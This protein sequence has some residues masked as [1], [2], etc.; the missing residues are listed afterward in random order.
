MDVT[1]QRTDSQ[2]SQT[3]GNG[4]RVSFNRDVHVKR[5]GSR[6]S[7][8]ESHHQETPPRVATPPVRREL[9]Q[10]LTE[11]GILAEAARVLS[12]AE[13]I[14]C[15]AQGGSDIV[16]GRVNTKNRGPIEPIRKFPE[17]QFNSLPLRGKKKIKTPV[18][19]SVSDASAKKSKKPSIFSLFG[20]RRDSEETLTAKKVARSKSDVGTVP[21]DRNTTVRKRNNSE[22]DEGVN[23]K[24]KAPPLSPIIE[25]TNKEDYFT[26][27]HENREPNARG[28]VKLED[29]D[30]IPSRVVSNNI[31]ETIT[32]LVTTQAK[33]TE[34]MHSSQLPAEK[35]PLTK[36][37]TVD[38]MVKRLSME[39]FSPPPQLA[40]PA[41]SYTRPKEQIIYAQ[42]VCDGDKT[43]QTVHYA[44]SHINGFH[45]EVNGR[46]NGRPSHSPSPFRDERSVLHL[47]GDRLIRKETPRSNSDEDEGLGFEIKKP[48]EENFFVDEGPITPNIRDVPPEKY[49][50]GD[51]TP[52]FQELSQRR[53]LLQSRINNRRFG[54]REILEDVSPERDIL[55]MRNSQ[56]RYRP[57]YENHEM[58]YQRSKSHDIDQVDNV[59]KYHKFGSQEVVNRYSPERSHLDMTQ[60]PSKSK[61]TS[62]YVEESRY[63]HDGKDGYRE[64]YRKETNIGT[65]GKPRTSESRSRERL[66]SPPRRVKEIDLGYIEDHRNFKV[67]HIEPNTSFFQDKYRGDQQPRSLESTT[68][69]D[70]TRSSP[71][72]GFR[73]NIR[74]HLTNG[75]RHES[76]DQYQ[77]SLKRQQKHQ[78]SFDKGDSGIENDYR[79]DSFN[80]DLQTR[81]KRR[82]IED[83]IKGCELFLRKERR[84]T[85]ENHPTRRH[86]NYIYRERSI[87]DGSHFDPRLDKYPDGTLRRS[88]E[89]SVEKTKTEK[90][91]SGLEKVKQLLTGSGKKKK[92]EKSA[93]EKYMVREDEMR[94]RYS[95]YRGPNATEGPKVRNSPKKCMWWCPRT[96]A[97]TLNYK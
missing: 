70:V 60:T 84:H 10:D 58:R 71:D 55:L 25:N 17:S 90:K 14:K 20:G 31:K 43:K 23:A 38:G 95:E 87:D 56:E 75:Y 45:S 67:G 88:R 92:D 16:G 11:E 3:N 53:E 65:D 47:N 42:V 36:G 24:K 76:M 62:K 61:V 59:K 93:K 8:A 64:T 5:I 94:A 37:R 52:A 28:P 51:R 6:Q 86:L 79:K 50:L 89:K 74:S 13:S 27:N 82:T 44:P 40:T 39:R 7:P 81:W 21:R 91:K 85:E 57:S 15:T 78:R 19:R 49:Y 22:N 4:P 2:R 32:N 96:S 33:S 35:P 18:T 63:Y 68:S 48:Y 77:N 54:S 83:D 1:I 9:P 29:L 41:F 12:Q 34:E 72:Q 97:H 80:G 73:Q 66:T 46:R 26:K 30:V 69:G